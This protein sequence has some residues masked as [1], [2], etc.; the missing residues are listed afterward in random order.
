V[1]IPDTQCNIEHITLFLW[2]YQPSSEPVL[3]N[4][5]L[6]PDTSLSISSQTALV[7]H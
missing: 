7:L 1:I 5:L 3:R 6:D 2:Y 4:L